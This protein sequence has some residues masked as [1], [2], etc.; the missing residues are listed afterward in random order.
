MSYY[1]M[2]HANLEHISTNFYWS[3]HYLTSDFREHWILTVG[4]DYLR[5]GRD[6][7]DRDEPQTV[8]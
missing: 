4:E 7:N 6:T 2:T 3:K 5:E 8:V 1:P